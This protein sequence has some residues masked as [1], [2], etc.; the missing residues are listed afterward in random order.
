MLGVGI[1]MVWDVGTFLRSQL[2][3]WRLWDDIHTGNWTFLFLVS[4]LGYKIVFRLPLFPGASNWTPSIFHLYWLGKEVLKE[5]SSLGSYGI[6]WMKLDVNHLHE[7]LFNG[8]HFCQMGEN[9]P[10]AAILFFCISLGSICITAITQS[11]NSVKVAIL[12]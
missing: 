9:M 4:F 2:M 5:C 11:Q 6:L 7:T 12:H 1:L 10:L 3:L 8:T